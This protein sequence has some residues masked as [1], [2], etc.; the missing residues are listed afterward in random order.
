M[1]L[2]ITKKL[3]DKLKLSPPP[4]T[5]TDEFLSWRSNYIQEHGQRFVVFM[6]DAS[7]FT[8]V[9][10]EAKAAKLKKL[11]ELFIETLRETLFAICVNPEVIGSYIADLG[12]ITYAKNS[13]RK[14]TAQLNKN[15]EYAWWGLRDYTDSV[16]L[17]VCANN[18]IYNT[19][20]TDEVI[21]PKKKML[22]L[23]GRYG[24]PVRK[25]RA[26]DLNVSLYLDGRDAIRRLRVPAAMSFDNLHK[27]LQTAFEWQN[28]HLHS[29]GLFKEWSENYYARPDVELVDEFDHYDEYESNRD[30]K[31]ITSVRLSDYVPEFRKILYTYDFGDDWHHYIEVENITDDCDE[32]LPL[33]LSG[34][35]DSPP[36]DV[37]GFSGFAEFLEVIADPEHEEYEHLTEWAK[38]QRWKPF[39]FDLVARRVKN[40]MLSL[41]VTI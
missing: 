38:S 20:G 35:G 5:V 1:L 36:E 34:E 31:S 14:R 29:F 33:L 23:L 6:N 24:L 11:L 26:L 37:G 9:I 40:R 19:S 18:A 10:N 32:E 3:A 39:D 25:F 27:L 15:T 8:V 2:H 4:G 30:A 13:D 7:R 17:S 16:K 28:Y 41:M 22:E 12:E 21:E